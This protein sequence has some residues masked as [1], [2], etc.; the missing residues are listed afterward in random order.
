M[1]RGV[2]TVSGDG[3]AGIDDPSM[4]PGEWRAKNPNPS[5][6][7]RQPRQ[8]PAWLTGGDLPGSGA[9]HKWANFTGQQKVIAIVVFVTLL[10]LLALA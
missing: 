1:V 7:T 9:F 3:V 2:P 5:K 4:G 8:P 10:A 6:A